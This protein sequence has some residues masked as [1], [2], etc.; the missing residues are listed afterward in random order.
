MDYL[1]IKTKFMFLSPENLEILYLK[2]IHNVPYVRH[3][4][5]HKTIAM[6]RRKLFC[7]EMKKDVVNYTVICMEC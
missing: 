2:E 3:L 7:L 5:Y 4:G 6:V 1:C